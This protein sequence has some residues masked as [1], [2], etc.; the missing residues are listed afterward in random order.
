MRADTDMVRH[1]RA[2]VEAMEPRRRRWLA[3]AADL[4][5]T[6]GQREYARSRADCLARGLRGRVGNCGQRGIEVKCDCGKKLAPW[7]CT[8][9]LVCWSCAANR[10]WRIVDRIEHAIR[11]QQAMLPCSRTLLLTLTAAHSV[12]RLGGAVLSR[13]EE[14]EDLRNR[15]AEG[16]RAFTKAVGKEWGYTPYVG[17]WEVTPGTSSR[18]HLHLHV[19]VQWQYRSWS[20]VAELWRECCPSSSRISIVQSFDD[21]NTSARRAAEYIAKYIGK[22][23]GRP[24][25][26][27]TAGRWTP[28][29]H[30][31]VH[32]ATYQLRWL[33]A[34][35]GH[36][37]SLEQLCPCCGQK[38]RPCDQARL[39]LQSPAYEDWPALLDMPAWWEAE[40]WR[41]MPLL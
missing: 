40:P 25:G 3:R 1:D 39:W 35:R 28:E 2:Y 6:D 23:R 13:A 38:P 32:A 14:L 36:L 11:R 18:G 7:R 34:A 26:R 19:V 24:N 20:K 15:L 30:A 21:P 16:W 17:V 9:S 22:T 12:R 4:G 33:F 8:K 5:L 41:Q 31:Y 37:P 27:K 10:R 29:L